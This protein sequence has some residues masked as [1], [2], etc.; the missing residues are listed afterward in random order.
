MR[1][2]LLLILLTFPLLSFALEPVVLQGMRIQAGTT[3]S[4]IIFTLSKKT[5]GRVKYVPTPPRV[6][7]EFANTIKHFS[8]QNAK[9]IGSNIQSISTDDIG[10][11]LRFIFY[12]D[13]PVRTQ[14]RFLAETEEKT[15]QLQLI[16]VSLNAKKS[17]KPKPLPV[18]FNTSHDKLEQDI[19]NTLSTVSVAEKN[20]TDEPAK[21]SVTARPFTVVIDA[22][23]GGKDPGALGKSG[24]KE[25]DVVLA[26]AKK[27]AKKINQSPHMRAVL[28]R[29]GDYYLALRQRLK[30]ARKD[31]ADLFIAIHADSYFDN[32]AMGASVYALSQKG[33]T[34]EAARWLA[35]RDNYDE[36]GDVDLG[37]LKDRSTMV[38]SVL[39]DLAQ[40]A[41]I[42]DSMRLGNEML[43]ALD[44]VSLLRYK[45]VEQAPFVVLKSPDIPS[46]LVETGFISNPREEQNLN[47]PAYQARIAAALWQGVQKYA[48]NERAG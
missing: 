11:N 46:I 21:T 34:N 30:L 3:E 27:L 39:I 14:I 5:A 8:I 4:R 2:W 15:A 35:Q 10:K 25:K 13:G 43:N 6:F 38:R 47:S 20:K 23:H 33:A 41:T 32:S 9:I 36:L 16:I 42:Q 45:H 40:T 44:D 12:V 48:K 19:L 18:T 22:G 37:E 28:T 1:K 24:S 7:V 29:D 26:I 17:A 31:K